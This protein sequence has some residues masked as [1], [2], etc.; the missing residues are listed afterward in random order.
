MCTEAITNS[1][2]PLLSTEDFITELFV[3]IDEQMVGVRKDPRA[4]LWPGEVVTLA[5]LFAIKGVHERAFYRWLRRDWLALFPQ[6]PER[7]RLLRL[8][9]AQRDGT[10]RLLTEDRYVGV[11]IRIGYTQYTPIRRV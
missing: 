9:A 11:A 10:E 6:L 4:K 8:F 5:L 1:L 2:L 7:P 3:R